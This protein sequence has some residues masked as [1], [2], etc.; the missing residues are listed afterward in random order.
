MYTCGIPLPQ[1]RFSTPETFHIKEY[2]L[3]CG[4]SDT[5]NCCLILVVSDIQEKLSD[6]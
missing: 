6:L 4:L 2:L 1:D 5:Q 3:V